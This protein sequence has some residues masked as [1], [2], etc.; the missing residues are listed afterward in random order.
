MIRSRTLRD[1]KRSWRQRRPVRNFDDDESDETII[2]LGFI[3][4]K[5]TPATGVFDQPAASD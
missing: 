2:A 1:Q 3:E 4:T 5:T